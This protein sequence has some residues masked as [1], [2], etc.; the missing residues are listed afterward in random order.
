[1]LKRILLY[2]SVAATAS[3][4]AVTFAQALEL[5]QAGMPTEMFLNRAV[6][7]ALFSFGW[8]IAVWYLLTAATLLVGDL[9]TL[10]GRS[11]TTVLRLLRLAGAPLLRHV[12][13]VAAV[14]AVTISPALAL[15]ADEPV[16]APIVSTAGH[17]GTD[18]NSSFLVD[19]G[20]GVTP[21]PEPALTGAPD[22][23]PI[24]QVVDDEEALPPDTPTTVTVLDGDTLWG[25]VDAYLAATRPGHTPADVAAQ[26]PRWHAHNATTIGPDPD[27]LLPG[28]TLQAPPSEES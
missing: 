4:L 22:P 10:A 24:P 3:I 26:W 15:P 19:L 5:P 25:I 13:A 12:A 21:P 1:M 20:W 27:L 7:S 8:V 18:R 17:T 16:S 14:S 28:T 6:T 11:P 2:I 23:A 9:L